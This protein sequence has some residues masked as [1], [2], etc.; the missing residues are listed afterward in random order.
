MNV[1]NDF[2]TDF[3]LF[4]KQPELY[5]KGK[6]KKASP[7][8]IGLTIVY[9]IIYIAFLIY[10]LVRM[11]KRIDVTFYDSYT[12]QGLPS[13]KLT[14]NEFY[15]GFGM[16]GI[17]DERMYRIEVYYVS[18]VKVNGAWQETTTKLETEIC[19]L[20][21]F[22]SEYQQIFADQP[23]DNYYCI[24][25]VEGMVLEGYSNMERFSYFNVKYYPCVGYTE[26]GEECYDY[27]TK[28]QFFAINTVELK[29]QDNDINPENYKHPVNRR[30]K[31]MNSPVFKDLFQ[32]IYSYI[33][34]VYIE[35]DED[36]TG[37]NFF[38]D[39]IRREV[40]TKYD[41]SFLIAA[42]SFYGDILQ[43]GGLIADVY[44]QLSAKVLT[45]K[46]QYTQLIDVLGD[47]GGLME[48]L[49][50]FLNILS[51]FVTEILYDKSLVNN[52]F[53]FDLNKK[54]IVIK[55]KHKWDK[56]S[57]TY[58][59]IDI[60][61][62]DTINLRNNIDNLANNKCEI[63]P[64]ENLGNK[65]MALEK[66]NIST[67]RKKVKVVKKKKKKKNSNLQNSNGQLKV[68]NLVHENEKSPDFENKLSI[69]E[70]T[71]VDDTRPNEGIGGHT[72]SILSSERELK[73]LY[74]NN[75]TICCFWCYRKKKNVNRVLFEEASRI[76]TENLD[77]I[78]IFNHLYINELMQEKLRIEEKDIEMSENC[79]NYLHLIHSNSINS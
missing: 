71:K 3:D 61:K 33:Q 5:Y 29:I 7:L 51:S 6:S 31:D 1:E 79:K 40:Y 52:L 70:N 66:D 78:N 68:S 67:T 72:G 39:T 45:E 18:K 20:E 62:I 73:S 42:P 53:S 2:L 58:P 63:I 48:I 16:G 14:N 60:R 77:I 23:L 76:I 56:E 64:K 43:T 35:T 13:I 38:T 26:K 10:K 24:K 25:S 32:F 34:I 47:V 46:R 8:G 49:L 11:V 27:A 69:K 59:G 19:K 21:W 30:A 41:S 22:G 17:V 4:G 36:L 54:L 74:I 12:F 37:L 15:G 50:T 57:G 44:L 28:A 55:S 75:W 9:I 65:Y